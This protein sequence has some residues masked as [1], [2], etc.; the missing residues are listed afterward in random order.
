M[1]IETT[2]QRYDLISNA[3]FDSI[4]TNLAN[5]SQESIKPKISAKWFVIRISPDLAT[6]ELLNIGVGIVYRKKLFT[7]IIPNTIPLET[8]YGKS[9]KENFSFL[10][11]L[12]NLSSESLK[13][14]Q[15]ISPHFSFSPLKFVSGDSTEEILNRLYRNMVTL[16]LIEAPEKQHN[17]LNLSTEDVRKKIFNAIKSKDKNLAE[18]V[19]RDGKNPIKI[20][21]NLGEEITLNNLQIWSTP[22]IAQQHT[23]FGAIVSTDYIQP[24][25]SEFYLLQ[26]TQDIQLASASINNKKEAGLFI[27]RPDSLPNNTRENV[28]NIIDRAHWLI[29]KNIGSNFTMEVES[30]IKT[31][32][33]RTQSFAA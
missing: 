20:P 7:K 29:K 30:N 21:P 15:S 32:I 13:A 9:S 16:N 17:K 3:D 12:L 28:D 4:L 8:L 23:K 22:N 10:L 14:L 1:A 6:G 2:V 5:L 26:A 11:H 33:N 31:L 18:R 27:Y 19:W 24:H 25:Y